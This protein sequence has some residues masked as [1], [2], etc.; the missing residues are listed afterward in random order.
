MSELLNLVVLPGTQQLGPTETQDDA[1]AS[2]GYQPED[3]LQQA[4]HYSLIPVLMGGS[5]LAR[6]AD[7]LEGTVARILAVREELEAALRA[8]ISDAEWDASADGLR[9][10]L[11]LLSADDNH[12][13]LRSAISHIFPTDATSQQ[14]FLVDRVP[15][16]EPSGNA[17]APESNTQSAATAITSQAG[18]AGQASA[19]PASTQAAAVAALSCMLKR[20]KASGGARGRLDETLVTVASLLHASNSPAWRTGIEAQSA[21]VS[22]D[23]AAPATMSLSPELRSELTQ[24]LSKSLCVVPPSAVHTEM[25]VSFIHPF[26]GEQLST[27]THPSHAICSGIWG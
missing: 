3:L 25:Q 20:L 19:A 27:L 11:N 16:T 10:A 21:A 8:T 2:P 26:L 9:S 4:S 18:I 5:S 6:S 14:N 13:L 22:P 15:S 12:G 7:G 23:P 17:A 1:A 24:G